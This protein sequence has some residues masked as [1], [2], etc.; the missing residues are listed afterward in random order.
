MNH[1]TY[2]NGQ[3]CGV[4]QPV[5]TSP[6]INRSKEQWTAFEAINI[7]LLRVITNVSDSIVIYFESAHL[8]NG[9]IV[10]FR[11]TR[12]WDI[13]ICARRVEAIN[14]S[15]TQTNARIDWKLRRTLNAN[16]IAIYVKHNKCNIWQNNGHVWRASFADIEK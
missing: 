5:E 2:N 15:A 8:F 13:L 11:W 7:N 6:N 4:H 16:I 9:S 3:L 12:N 1:H 10:H 14:M